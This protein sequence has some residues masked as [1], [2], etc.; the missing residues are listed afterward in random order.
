MK[1]HPTTRELEIIDARK[2]ISDNRLGAFLRA[3]L[4]NDPGILAVD[5]ICSDLDQGLT[6]DEIFYT[7]D[8]FGFSISIYN[9]SESD[10]RI[11]FG[12]QAGPL[13]GDG[14]NWDVSFENDAV[15]SISIRG[16]W[17]S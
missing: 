6:L 14:G 15:K 1:S 16:S 13:A 2:E 11:G 7:G 8:E 10:F 4:V 5:I 17:I 9:R 12:C 3:A